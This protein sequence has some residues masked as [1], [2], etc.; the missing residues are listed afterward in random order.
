MHVIDKRNIFKYI[1]IISTT[2]ATSS[3][4]CETHFHAST[5]VSFDES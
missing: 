3:K 5:T 4:P 1:M 2:T